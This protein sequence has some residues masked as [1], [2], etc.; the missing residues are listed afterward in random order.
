MEDVVRR[1]VEWTEVKL[2]LNFQGWIYDATDI[3]T[4]AINLVRH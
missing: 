2:Q 4:E 3:L 1:I